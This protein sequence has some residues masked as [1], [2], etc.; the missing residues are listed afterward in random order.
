[1]PLASTTRAVGSPFSS[2]LTPCC[3]ASSAGRLD[4]LDDRRAHEHAGQQQA[5]GL[6]KTARRVTA[7]VV[8]STVTSVNCSC[9]GERIGRAVVELQRRLGASAGPPLVSWPPAARA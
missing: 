3:G 5:V 7:P 1:M 8:G 4:A 6:G 9:A 2:R